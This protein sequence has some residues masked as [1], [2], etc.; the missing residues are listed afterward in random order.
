MGRR[1]ARQQRRRVLYAGFLWVNPADKRL[2]DV[3][4][5]ALCKPQSHSNDNA[6]ANADGYPNADA[7]AYAAAYA[8]AAPARHTA[9]APDA[10]KAE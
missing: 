7:H 5:T 6:Y 9:P 1:R 8:Y 4:N 10:V 3:P 2:Q